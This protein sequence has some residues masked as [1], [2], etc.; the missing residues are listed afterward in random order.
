[1]ALAEFFETSAKESGDAKAASNWLMGDISRLM[2]DRGITAEQLKFTPNDLAELI[3]L[4]NS[5]TISNNIGKKVVEEM[6]ETGKAPKTIVEE[7]GLVQNSDE[8]AIREAV[9]KILEN[10]PKSV[11][12]YKNGKT[13]IIGF[14]VGLVMKEMKGKAN[15]QIANKL[16]TE[17]LN[18]I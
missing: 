10:N 8:G 12:D 18:K 17:E 4:I 3:K 9:I 7:K 15:P 14:V 6:F 1:M 13:R 16:V 2:N 11:E 5:G